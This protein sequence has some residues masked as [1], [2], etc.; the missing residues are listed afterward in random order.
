MLS[1]AVAGDT[2]AV[3]VEM[4]DMYLNPITDLK[5][6]EECQIHLE[7]KSLQADETVAAQL[8]TAESLR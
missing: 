7:L 8:V 5:I 4:R 2:L 6:L 1:Q 3:R